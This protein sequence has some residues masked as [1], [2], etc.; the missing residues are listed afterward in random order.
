M[1]LLELGLVLNQEMH[2]ELCMIRKE[3]VVEAIEKT[4]VYCEFFYGHLSR[5][6][7]SGYIQEGWEEEEKE[8]EGGYNEKLKYCCRE[9]VKIGL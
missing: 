6:E 2:C 9:I 1:F 7:I 8:G 4:M 3:I 5:N